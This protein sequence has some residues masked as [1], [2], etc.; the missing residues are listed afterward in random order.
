M[1]ALSSKADYLVTGD[2]T[3]FGK[4][5]GKKIQNLRICTPRGFFN[6]ISK[7]SP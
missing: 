4:Y 3:H 6:I 7:R 2:V 5:F 1:A